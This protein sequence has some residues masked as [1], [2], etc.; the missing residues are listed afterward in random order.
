TALGVPMLREEALIGVLLIWNEEVRPFTDKQI[1]LV[2]TF[3]DQAVIA[4]E[5]VRLF[6]E[7][8]ARTR[9]LTRSVGELQALG[10]VSQAVGSTLELETVLETIVSHAVQLSG[11]SAGIIYEFDVDLQTFQ[12]RV[13]HRVTPEHLAAL[14]TAPVRLGEGAVGSAGV[15]PE[16]VPGAAVQAEWQ[17]VAPQVREIHAREGTRS[18]LAV[19]LIREGRLAG[20]LVVLRRETGSF[21]PEVLTLLQT[22]AAQ[23]VLAIHNAGL[24]REVQRQK[25]Y[26]D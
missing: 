7:L 13:T 20:G 10:E 18:L 19:P 2:K 21:S 5:N 16:P 22:L 4:I 12:V 25:Q 8:E 1:E 15:I 11:S 3:A 9:D 24:F 17:L 23:S 6:Q 14:Q 26:A